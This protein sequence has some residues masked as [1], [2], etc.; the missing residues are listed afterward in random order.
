[1]FVVAKETYVESCQNKVMEHLKSMLQVMPKLVVM[2]W[3]SLPFI[4]I[5][6]TK[7]RFLFET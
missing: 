6:M 4:N 2:K 3:S 7:I 5:L 1:M